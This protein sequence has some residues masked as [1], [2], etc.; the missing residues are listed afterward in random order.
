[1]QPLRAYLLIFSDSGCESSV[2]RELESLC[3]AWKPYSGKDDITGVIH[4]GFGRPET[5]AFSLCAQKYQGRMLLSASARWALVSV[6]ECSPMIVGEAETI[7]LFVALNGWG[8]ETSAD[9]IGLANSVADGGVSTFASMK[10]TEPVAEQ[11]QAP[12]IDPILLCSVD[13]LNLPP[14]PANCLRANGVFYI[15]DLIQ[16]TESDLY[17]LPNFGMKS[18][19]DINSALAEINLPPI[20]SGHASDRQSAE[21]QIPSFVSSIITTSENT[22]D[23]IS[24]IQSAPPWLF[25]VSLAVLGLQVRTFR[26]LSSK[27]FT[28]VGDIAN[29]TREKLLDIPNFGRTSFCDLVQQL[30]LAIERGI[31]LNTSNQTFANADENSSSPTMNNTAIKLNSQF[32]NLNSLT[33]IIL[34]AVSSL[35]P[36]MEKAV[37]KRMGLNSAPMILEDIG[38]EMDIT[39]ERV[40]QLEANGL[41]MIGRDPVWENVLE[42]KLAKL[43]DGRD[44]PLPFFGLSIL[45]G[46]FFGIEQ[47]KE[48]FNYLLEHKNILDR[49]FSLIQTNGQLY[50]SRL[51]QNEWDKAERLAMRLLEGGVAD[52]WS[53]SEARRRVEDLLGVVGHE[54]RSE[55]WAAAKRFA[56]F[57]SPHTD[58]EPELVSYGRSTE[59]LVEAVLSEAD[60][61]LHYSEIPQRVAERYGKSIE[62]RRAHAA[63]GKVALLYGKGFYGFLKHCPLNYQERELVREEVLEA[64]SHGA[65]DRQWSCAE[66]MDILNE[67]GLDFDGRLNAYTLNI[68]LIGSSEIN[69]LG[70]YLW[71]QSGTASSGASHRIDIRQAVTSLLMQAGKPMSTS[72]IKET[73]QKD[74]GISNSFQ[75][76]PGESIIS[77]GIGLWGLIERDLPL[78]AAE[79]AQLIDALQKMLQNR[80]TGIHISE[81]LPCLEGVFEPASRI[82]DPTLIFAVAQRSGLMRKSAGGYLFLPEWGEP[83]RLNQSQAILE[84][85]RQSGEH[86]LTANEIVKLASALL[87]REIPRESR[88]G[89]ISAAGA[90]FDEEKKRWVI[91]SAA[92]ELDDA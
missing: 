4:V 82:K 73:L 45:D 92:D 3:E 62:V 41:S 77:V 39:R 88:Y 12:R 13:H 11:E 64:I 29:L 90:R 58:G 9:E 68:S 14:R 27:R 63:A 55:L 84:V 34:A 2:H 32:S 17:H 38:K 8:Y 43:L 30:K 50:V 49:R 81:I 83:R 89:H 71:A 72:E 20:K 18:L 56:H 25:S 33:S 70:R 60:R 61:P 69:Y 91:A 76:F 1:M 79:Q 10:H 66:L 46:W 48:P 42:A 47:M 54:M 37:N 87:G 28:I 6:C 65:S 15:R 26:A 7:P 44:E 52:G 78:D 67:R 80:K 86:G 75:I 35:P 40:R 22:D 51:S 53:L 85:L 21:L 23:F 36:N 57:S 24:L 74:R 31:S 19:R 59:A 5:E 16:C